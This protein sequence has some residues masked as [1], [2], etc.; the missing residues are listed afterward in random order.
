MKKYKILDNGDI[1]TDNGEK[2]NVYRPAN[3]TQKQNLL[4]FLEQNDFVKID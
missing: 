3:E 2:Y 4:T 1:W